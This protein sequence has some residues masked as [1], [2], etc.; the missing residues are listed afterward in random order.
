MLMESGP[1]RKLRFA[2]LPHPFPT[3]RP[4]PSPNG[5]NGPEDVSPG[6]V[7]LSPTP[8]PGNDRKAASMSLGEH[9]DDK[10]S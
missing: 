1:G 9:P 4:G 10:V 5:R 7:S 2:I 6:F 3:F 8:R